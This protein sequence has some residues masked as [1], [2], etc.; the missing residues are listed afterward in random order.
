MLTHSIRGMATYRLPGLFQAKVDTRIS[1]QSAVESDTNNAV[2]QS[3]Y[4]LV[5]L[6][7]SYDIDSH[8]S[9]SL[10]L[11]NSPTENNCCHCIKARP[12]PIMAHRV[13]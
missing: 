10:N 4:A 1:W 5:D 6:M 8:W 11:N 9:T 13:V 12:V 7:A 3:A 2:R